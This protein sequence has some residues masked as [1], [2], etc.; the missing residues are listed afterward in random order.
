[1]GPEQRGNGGWQASAPGGL[2]SDEAAQVRVPQ[3]TTAAAVLAL[4]L[5]VDRFG[6]RPLIVRGN[7]EF[8]SQVARLAGMG[9]ISIAFA[10]PDLERQRL[11]T[12][13]N[14]NRQTEEHTR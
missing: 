6:R 11:Q 10:D 13:R 12:R 1:M 7:E 4:S 8:R 14:V 5:A 9:G 3:P 2:V